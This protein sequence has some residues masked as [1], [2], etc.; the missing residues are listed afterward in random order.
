MHIFLYV[1]D[2]SII[3]KAYCA[4]VEEQRLSRNLDPPL[5]FAPPQTSSAPSTMGAQCLRRTPVADEGSKTAR[6][7]RACFINATSLKKHIGEFRQSLLDDSSC[8]IFGVAESRLEDQ[9]ND[10]LLK[11]KGYSTIRQNRNTASGGVLLYVRNGL[12]A[13]VLLKSKTSQKGKPKKT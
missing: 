6:G 2:L 10:H 3:L 12:K 9:V 5:T 7:I 11:V 4:P 1:E 8:H 13:K